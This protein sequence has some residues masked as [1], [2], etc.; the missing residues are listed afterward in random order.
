MAESKTVQCVICMCTNTE[1]AKVKVKM[2]KYMYTY[3]VQLEILEVSLVQ[4]K[5]VSFP[6][7]FEQPSAHKK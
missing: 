5:V 7:L 4:Y 6:F 3:L 2:T 1:I